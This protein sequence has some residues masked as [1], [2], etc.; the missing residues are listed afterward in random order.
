[1]QY[2]N[3]QLLDNIKVQLTSVIKLSQ[4]SAI[5]MDLTYKLEQAHQQLQGHMQKAVYQDSEVQVTAKDRLPEVPMK[6]KVGPTKMVE[7]P[8]NKEEH[9]LRNEEPLQLKRK[10]P[11]VHNQLEQPEGDRVA[12]CG[13]WT[14]D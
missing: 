5:N 4:Q 12:P 6:K 14:V 11:E 13:T 3:Q 1:M 7:A 2:E 8:T 9:D 10:D